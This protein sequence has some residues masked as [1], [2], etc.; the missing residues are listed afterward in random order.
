M[1][2]LTAGR[3]S[4]GEMLKDSKYMSQNMSKLSVKAH[5]DFIRLVSLY[6]TFDDLNMFLFLNRNLHWGV[7]KT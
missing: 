1:Q 5:R 2:V 6:S 4:F 3:I 7:F